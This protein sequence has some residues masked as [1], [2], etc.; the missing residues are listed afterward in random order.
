VRF[1]RLEV[2]CYRA[3]DRAEVDFGPGLNVLYG[4]NDL[5]KTTLASAM[6]AALLLP[7]ESSA[8]Q[9][10]VA[11]HGADS[12]RVR[13]SF[14]RHGSVWRVS[15]S[16]GHGS[17]ASARLESSQDGSSF[18]D[19]ERGRAVDRR[20]REL[21][22]WGIDAPGGKGGARGL[23]E[24]FLS[25]V[26]LASQ[27][28]VSQILERTLGADRD[29]S[30]REQLHEALQAL[31]QD[32]LFKRVLEAAAAKVDSAFTPTG[33]RKTGQSSPF[34]PLKEQISGLT[35]EFERLTHQRRESEDVAQRITRLNEERLAAESQLALLEQRV[36]RARDALVQ[37]KSQE[38]VRERYAAARQAVQDK[39]A[40]QQDLA[41]LE[42]E[43]AEASVRAEALAESVTVAAARRAEAEAR[44]AQAEAALAA[45]NTD[46]WLQHQ[47]LLREQLEQEQL[48]R[49]ADHQ[50]AQELLALEQAVRAAEEAWRVESVRLSQAEQAAAE[51]RVLLGRAD[52]ELVLLRNLETACQWREANQSAERARLAQAEAAKLE[53][54][55]VALR[56]GAVQLA[57]PATVLAQVS[58]AALSELRH[59]EGQLRVAEA[60][61]DVGLSMLVKLPSGREVALSIDNA[62]DV[63]R[64]GAGQP[65]VAQARNRIVLRLADAVEVEATAGDRERRLELER[66][67]ARWSREAAPLLEAAGVGSIDA[68]GAR[69]EAERARERDASAALREAASLEARA[70]EKRELGAE[71][72]LWE[73]RAEQHRQALVGID[74]ATL[75]EPLERLGA[76]WEATLRKRLTS[77]EAER[78]RLR[79]L[80]ESHAAT[81]VH[82]AAR[83][84]GLTEARDAA[85][86]CRVKA[87]RDVGYPTA[88]EPPQLSEL[89]QR[90]SCAERAVAA[91]RA[92]RLDLDQTHSAE[93]AAARRGREQASAALT[94][95]Q[96]EHDTAL[97]SS[98]RARESQLTLLA[99][100][101]ERNL[102]VNALGLDAAEAALERAEID[103]QSLPQVES[104]TPE[105]LAE[106]EAELARANSQL[107]RVLSELR[108]AEG[109]L[110]HVGGDVVLD[111]Q[112]RT[113]EALERARELEIDQEREYDAYLLLTQTLRA[114][115]NEQGA[116]LGR[117][118]SAPVSERFERLTEGRYRKVALDAGLGLDGVLVAGHARGFRELSEGTQ[119]QLATI[120]RLCIAEQLESALVLDDH[121][122]QTHRQRAEWFRGA[123][124]EAA[125][126]IQIIVLTARPEDYLAPEELCD[127]EP[128]RDVPG[129]SVRA[130]DLERVIVRA[131]YGTS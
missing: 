50:R 39:Q 25:H 9:A 107:S 125:Q 23:P 82:A 40:A 93:G 62:P 124:R 98:A 54:A 18:R 38:G 86:A 42:A 116:H 114:V 45:Q 30:G 71:L 58:P 63:T 78:A 130:I 49:Q 6:R 32:P 85:R 43:L 89:E 112:Q 120:L 27:A 105:Q 56:A 44:L 73:Q 74:L 97:S 37:L 57:A 90:V 34:A 68:L 46:G 72:L 87:L 31:A 88:A 121:L 102:H 84:S 3:V 36:A 61:L 51:Q 10:F 95:A 94:Q 100:F 64:V 35:R 48:S 117:A 122:A 59:L 66:L 7:A 53:A 69:L 28:S 4:P 41:R 81:L 60:R 21:L 70:A 8:H 119:E 5:G 2:Q 16:F 76:G 128:M 47:A 103:L 11:W 108:R 67:Q 126:R 109:A 111:S 101:R 1:L 123:L 24:S 29:A 96:R 22:S 104:M 15:K 99:Q 91:V 13:L 65:L 115:E 17:L 131:S 77:A 92:K 83:V 106:S 118:L 14:E 33:R 12:P 26:L 79:L 80:L 55:A 127:A 19:E 75:R 113:L 20:L 110:G 52:E 129:A